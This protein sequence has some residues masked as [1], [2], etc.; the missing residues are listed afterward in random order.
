MN[1]ELQRA[2]EADKKNAEKY[3]QESLDKLKGKSE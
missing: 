2:L 3:F 1:P